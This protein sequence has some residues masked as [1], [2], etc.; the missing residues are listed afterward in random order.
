MARLVDGHNVQELEQALRGLEFLALKHDV[1]H[2]ARQN[3][4]PNAVIAMLERVPKTEFSS[5]ED[6]IQSY[7]EV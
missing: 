1:I 3:G 6:V 5:R 7:G 2:A 4:A